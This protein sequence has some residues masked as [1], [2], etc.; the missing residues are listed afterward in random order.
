MRPFDSP[1]QLQQRRQRA[2]R[3]LQTGVAPVEVARQLG[4]DRRSVRR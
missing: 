1:A 2:I 3:L 4:V